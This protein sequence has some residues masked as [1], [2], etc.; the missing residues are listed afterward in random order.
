MRVI[1]RQ[2]FDSL[3]DRQ[4]IWT[5]IE[6]T[7][8]EIRGRDYATKAEAY[9]QLNPGQQA[10]LMFQVLYGHTTHGAAEFYNHLAYLLPNQGVWSAL[11]NGIQYFEDNEL[12]RLLGEMEKVYHQ[13]EKGTAIG[14]PDLQTMINNLDKAIGEQIPK[15]LKA[16]GDYIKE[17]PSDFVIIED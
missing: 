15:T 2:I 4:L 13:I 10:L 11:K 8:D 12:L 1:R 16:V 9:I 7:I 5:C 17:H 14:T 3:D 6:P